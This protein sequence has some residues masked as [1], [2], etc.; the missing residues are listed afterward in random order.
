MRGLVLPGTSIAGH[1]KV[2][3]PIAQEGTIETTGMALGGVLHRLRN[4][5]IQLVLVTVIQQQEHGVFI[6][7][8]LGH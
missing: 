6:V 8:Q 4:D 1:G 3:L 2:I 7:Q 5:M